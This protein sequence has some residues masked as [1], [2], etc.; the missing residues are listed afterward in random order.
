MSQ[1]YFFDAPDVVITPAV[2]AQGQA[3][4]RALPTAVTTPVRKFRG[5]TWQAFINEFRQTATYLRRCG[6]FRDFVTLVASELDLVRIHTPESRA[7]CRQITARYKTA[8]TGRM[9]T[10]FSFMVNALSEAHQDFLG[11][12][13]METRAGCR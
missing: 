10:L 5:E 11:E 8:D 9:H 1:L 12:V 3:T 6:V 13:Y 2:P 4:A 7:R